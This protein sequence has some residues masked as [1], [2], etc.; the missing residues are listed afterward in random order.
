[1]IS[2]PGET[3]SWR[4]VPAAA[5]LA[6]AAVAVPVAAQQGGEGATVLAPL[7]VEGA[8]ERGT[9]PV[10]GYVAGRSTTGSKTDTP[11][12]ENPQSISVISRERMDDQ[13]VR[14]VS[15]ALRYTPGV[16]A[17][18]YGTDSRLDW[19]VI[20][21]FQQNET[22]LYRDNLRLRSTGYASW[23]VDPYG[24][25]RIEVIRGP[26]SVLYGQIAPGG[27]VNLVSKRAPEEPLREIGVAIGSRSK[28]ELTA[29]VGGPVDAAGRLLF[30][31]T[32]LGR[33]A[34]TQV[35]DVDEDRLYLAPTVTWRPRDGTELTLLASYQRDR[36]GAETNFLPAQ[37]TFRF[38]PNGDISTTLFT[39]E[40]DFDEYD[41]DQY[42]LGYRLEQEVG[43]NLTLR[44][45][46]RYDR[47]ELDYRALYGLGLQEDLRT[48]NR[49]TVTDDADAD[50]FAIDNQGQLDNVV[51][52]VRSTLL[53]GVD[54]TRS[55]NDERQGFGVGPT[56]DVFDPDYGAF[57]PEAPISLDNETTLDQLGVYAQEQA[58]LWDRL[59][60][61]LGG[62]YDW[63][64]TSIDDALSGQKSQQD[65]EK[66]TWRAGLTYLFDN[67][68]APYAS[69]ATSFNP[70]PGTDVE[71]DPFQPDKGEQ[72]EVGLK[73]QPPGLDAFV[74]LAAF[75]LSRE[76]VLTTDP[77]DPTNQIQTGEVNVQGIEVEGVASP[78]AG[79]DLVASYSYLKAEIQES[80]AGDEGNRPNAV[81]AHLASAWG[82]YE[83]QSGPL[84]GLG[85][86]AGV[87]YV[88]NQE[89]DNLNT[90]QVPDRL[91]VDGA[92]HYDIAGARLALNVANLLDDTFVTSCANSANACYYG[93]RRSIVGS[94]RLRW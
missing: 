9:G 28:R 14:T 1:M 62:R 2:M 88:G 72:Y 81:P 80:E 6:I 47:L 56:L 5:G 66:F 37:G 45:N 90:D 63:T 78:V 74:T 18:P 24:L 71:G 31:L 4:A 34:E 73:Y 25:E 41:K 61:T 54:A 36:T 94:V 82:R 10:G 48:L 77:I 17:E 70:T 3:H 50:A 42:G 12:I 15:D 49:G 65:D 38:N 60:V 64:Y 13:G 87:R 58:T 57:V 39:S 8:A 32:A 53:A 92:V 7:R 46:V 23:Q 68:L 89:V 16:Q 27:L 19:F 35:D 52:P 40:P 43:A 59:V 85:L 33:L 86:G 55:I 84:Q 30:R 11:L 91:L 79:L 83:L 51:G 69:Y 67:G 26:N 44:Q 76:N 20:R 21:G 75:D 29:D 22:G 93:E